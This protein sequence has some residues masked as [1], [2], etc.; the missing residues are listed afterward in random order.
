MPSFIKMPSFIDKET[1]TQADQKLPDIDQLIKKIEHL[2]PDFISMKFEHDS[3]F[4]VAAACFRDI[5][6]TLAETRY[7]LLE[8]LAHK[9]W[10]LEKTNPPNELAAVFFSRFYI[11]DAALRL[12]SAAEH[13]AKAAVYILDIDDNKIKA[14]RGG[15]RFVTIRKI[16]LEE[17]PEHPITRAI[18][19]L[20]KSKEW[21]STVKYRDSWVHQ[22]PPIIKGLGVVYERERRWKR[23][24]TGKSYTLGVGSG[25]DKAQ[26]SID[27][28]LGFICPAVSQFIDKLTIVVDFYIAE[29]SKR[30]ITIQSNCM[31]DQP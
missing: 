14:N 7:A 27:D 22:Q 24:E 25:G 21:K 8:S 5:R 4:P 3:N 26:Y 28:L 6:T 18:D 16:L 1:Y 11:D 13:L 2:A 9:T 20:Y 30:G 17:K 19:A 31:S 23:S 15:S 10:Y 12:Y 29:L